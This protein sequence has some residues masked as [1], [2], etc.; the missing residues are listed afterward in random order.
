MSNFGLNGCIP[1]LQNTDDAI[2]FI[3]KEG[4]E[5][6][7]HFLLD[8]SYFRNNFNSLWNKLKL[9]IA[10]S[11]QTD[12]VY[13]CNFITNLDRNNTVLLLSGGLALPLD[14][15][16][17]IKIKRFISA[18]VGKIYKLRQERLCELE[19]PWLANR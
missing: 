10:Q 3:C 6:V 9:K 2:C 8:C 16:A 1:W 13:I 15:K 17:N 11:N 5:S 12:R 19:A 18:A 14:S 7:T 4:I